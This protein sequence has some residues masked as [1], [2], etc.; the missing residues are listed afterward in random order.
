MTHRNDK[1]RQTTLDRIGKGWRKRID[2]VREYEIVEDGEEVSEEFIPLIQFASGIGPKEQ[3]EPEKLKRRLLEKYKGK[4]LEDVIEGKEIKTEKG[5]CYHIENQDRIGLKLINQKHARM[6]ILSDLK[7]IYGIGEVTEC[8]LKNKGY[9]TIEDLM[10][11]P[12]FS[13]EAIR[14]LKII[15][16]HD[17][18]QIIDLIAHRFL[19]SHPLIL[20][21]SAFQNKEDFVFFD[22]ETMGLSTSPIILFGVAQ[23]SGGHVLINQYLLRE[24][25]EEPAALMSFLSHLNETSVFITFNGRKFDIPYISVRLA[26]YRMRGDLE[27]PHFDILHFSRRAW[28]ERLPNCRF[29]TLEKY[30]LGIERK[31]DV[32]SALVPDF[33]ETYLRSKNIGPLIR[34][35]E[36]NKQDLVTLANIFSKLHEEWG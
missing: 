10:E 13:S 1:K 12:R 35:I 18:C 26:Y 3:Q 19:K 20:C 4:K 5:I 16:K 30:L 11:H 32:P 25:K 31:D 6:K 27:K 24:I 7:L 14:F 28:R 15:D 2:E 36:H 8:I 21:C 17:T 23:I 9:N 22:I 34:I 29:N 33:Y